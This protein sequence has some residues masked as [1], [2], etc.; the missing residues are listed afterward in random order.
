MADR[1]LT[2]GTVI[3]M[4][5]DVPRAQA[6]AVSGDT[7]VAVGSVDDCLAALPD[8]ELVDTGGCRARAGFR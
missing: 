8:A 2:A 3:T 1:I 5:G 6:V 7:I 4:D